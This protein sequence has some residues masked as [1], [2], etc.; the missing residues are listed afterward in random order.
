MI[1]KLLSV[2]LLSLLLISGTSFQTVE[3]VGEPKWNCSLKA[4][5]KDLY[6]PGKY[7]VGKNLPA[8]EYKLLAK[9]GNAYFGLTSDSNGDDIIVNGIFETQS[10]VTVA[11]GQYLELRRCVAISIDKLDSSTNK[12]V[13][14]TS[15]F[16]DYMFNGVFKA[17]VDFEPGEYTIDSLG[18]SSY[19]A[20]LNDS[21]EHDI[22]SNSI[23][24]N[25]SFVTVKEGQYLELRRA[26]ISLK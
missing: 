20:V 8:G 5:E 22:D 10:Y 19:V 3:A 1:K 25:Q 26:K 17:G 13:A 24:E 4:Y 6:K 12:F 16:S 14:P 15:K 7:K 11:E 9:G 21:S 18:D 23:F 2:F